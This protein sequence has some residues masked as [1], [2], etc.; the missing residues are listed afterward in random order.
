MIPPALGHT[1]QTAYFRQNPQDLEGF[2]LAVD[3]TLGF[4]L[5]LGVLYGWGLTK[6]RKLPIP[7]WQ[8]TCFYGGLI[9]Q[10]LML[11]PWLDNL[12]GEM[13]FVHMIQHLGIILLGVP[14][15]LSGAPFFIIIRSLPPV[16]KRRVYFPLLRFYP[17]QL[18]HKTLRNPVVALCLFQLNFW[19]WHLPTWYNLALY[20][21][22]YHILEHAC[23]A[24]SALYFWSLILD[25]HPLH[26]HLPMGVRI[27]FL[28]SFMALN[29]ILAAMLTYSHEIWYA[30]ENIP[31]PQWWSEQWTR[32]DD[33]RLGGLIMWVPGS[34]VTFL[35]MTLTFFVWVKRENKRTGDSITAPLS[36]HNSSSL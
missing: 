24:L 29:I 4:F 11:N 2:S 32:L 15:I 8:I 16:L 35:Y 17:L 36:N 28:A 27:L 33:Q 22:G 23:M 12:A 1:D 13:F 20:N 34:I 3:P 14:M 7:L 5:L 21:D 26:S 6:F 25:P 18:T 30:Y 9:W 10:I 31:L 19:F